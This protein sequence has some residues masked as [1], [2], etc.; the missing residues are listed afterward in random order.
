MSSQKKI[1]VINVMG[2]VFMNPLDD[3][4][5]SIRKVIGDKLLGKM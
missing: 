5:D 4:F 2:R 1:L 3:P